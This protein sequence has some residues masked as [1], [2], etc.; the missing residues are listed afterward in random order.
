MDSA[1]RRTALA[2]RMALRPPASRGGQ[3][4]AA[5]GAACAVAARRRDRR[6]GDHRSCV[7]AAY[8]E[9]HPPTPGTLLHWRPSPAGHAGRRASARRRG[10]RG[11]AW[12]HRFPL[13][14]LGV[15]TAGVVAFSL[16]GYVNGAALLL[17]AVATGHARRA[18]PI[19]RSVAWAVAVTAV[20]MAATAANNP[21]GRVRRRVHPDPRHFA[22]ALFAGIAVANRRAYVESLRDRA[23]RDA[24]RQVDEERL[25][26]ARELHDVVAHTMATMTSPG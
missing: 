23:E 2:A 10:G 19:R 11:L 13:P 16:L 24:R 4:A 8:G 22:V 17:P 25:R 1:R 20:L 14:V 6:G 15:S 9:A 18:G 7:V 5:R 21:L 12:R 3:P 26:I